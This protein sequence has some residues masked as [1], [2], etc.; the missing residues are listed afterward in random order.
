MFSM[1][2]TVSFAGLAPSTGVPRIKRSQ[3]S[4]VEGWADAKS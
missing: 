2:A 3:F 1:K 4:I